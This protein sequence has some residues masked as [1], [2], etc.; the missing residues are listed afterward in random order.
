MF[1]LFSLKK[2]LILCTSIFIMTNT[3]FSYDDT[4]IRDYSYK[5]ALK[6]V[7]LKIGASSFPPFVIVDEEK[8][9]HPSGLEIDILNE[10][11]KRLGYTLHNNR[12]IFSSSDFLLK[13]CASGETDIIIAGF[14]L[15]KERLKNFQFSPSFYQ[16]SQA[17]VTKDINK[18]KVKSFKDLNNKTLSAELGLDIASWFKDEGISVKVKEYET[19]FMSYYGI[20]K[21]E[22]FATVIDTPNAL[23][24]IKQWPQSNLAIAFTTNEDNEESKIGFLYK[25]DFKYAPYFNLAINDMLKDGTI[26]KIIDKYLK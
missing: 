11:Q 10:V 18:D 2:Y 4:Y 23:Y 24:Y 16:S 6:G 17:V 26:D 9:T 25:K 14:S 8:Y 7:T 19:N 21:D 13:S 20:A 15:T 5:D 3:A 22:A 12:Y 1:S